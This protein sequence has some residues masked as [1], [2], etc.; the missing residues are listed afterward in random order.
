MSFNATHRSSAELAPFLRQTTSGSQLIVDGEPFLILGGELHNSTFSSAELMSTIW[1]KMKAMNINTV[2]GPVTWEIIEPTEGH[3]DFSELDKCLLGAR[4]HGLHLVL[5][6]F[7]SYKNATS[8]Y[9]PDWVKTD[10]T[11]FPRIQIK[12]GDD[13]LVTT[14]TLQPFSKELWQADAT[15]FKA[16]M[17]HIKEVDQEHG[18][19]VMVQVENEIGIMGGS[20]DRSA[21]ADDLFDSPVPEDLLK[22][23]RD[24]F[25]VLSPS[26]KSKFAHLKDTWEASLTWKQAFGED[27]WADD[28]F[29]ANAFSHFVQQVAA[30]GRVEY[31]IPI[32]VNVA[33]CNEDPSWADDIDI[34]DFIPAG[35]KP[36][37]YP[38]GGPV[39]HNLDIYMHNAPDID[40]F[41]PDIYLQDY[42]KVSE[43]FRPQKRA[44]FIPEQRRDEYGARRIWSG[45][46]NHAAIGCCPFGIDGFTVE[47]SPFTLHFG[48]LKA[49]SSYILEAQ[50]NRP[51][52]IMG[53][54]FDEVDETQK[55][56][57]WTKVMGDFKVTVERAFVFG[58]PSSGAGIIIRQ[59]NGKF[60]AA[61]FGFQVV[62]TSTDPKS[63]FT[64]ILR[65]EEKEVDTN[66]ALHTVR[67]LNGDETNQGRVLILPSKCPD[68]GNFPVPVMIPARTMIA[69][70]LPYSLAQ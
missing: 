52:E 68:L 51:D 69:E 13:E 56:R 20:R 3:F 10:G 54:Y 4:K 43:C 35:D 62:F 34:P 44:L 63:T 38:S 39:G 8:C 49:I 70:C 42:E 36:G 45:Y 7:G 30:A 58:K 33:L 37:Q 67:L 15:A 14:S 5:L 31:D 24:D 2:L 59:S 64:G 12:G 41:A 11:R 17:K 6:W 26:F 1:P 25:D 19:V 27:H 60:L 50:A 18:T 48:I 28:L 9:A 21:V 23:L 57:K 47:E 22:R 66:G 32:F 53:F 55:E 29:M 40:F 61:G 16:L 46:G 65:T